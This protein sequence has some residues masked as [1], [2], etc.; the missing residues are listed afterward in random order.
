MADM[1][2]HKFGN[3]EFLVEDGRFVVVGGEGI[4]AG[5]QVLISYGAIDNIWLLQRFELG[6]TWGWEWSWRVVWWV[7]GG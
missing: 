7:R 2:N 1:L 6:R 4:C 5:E 3:T